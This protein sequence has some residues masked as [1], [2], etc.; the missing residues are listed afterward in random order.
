MAHIEIRPRTTTTDHRLHVLVVP[1][2]ECWAITCNGSV[3]GC[4]CPADIEPGDTWSSLEPA[5]Q[6]ALRHVHLHETRAA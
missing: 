3:I 6:D 5:V 1:L 2:P 4:E